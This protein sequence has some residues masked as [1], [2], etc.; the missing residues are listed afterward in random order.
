MSFKKMKN[1]FALFLLLFTPLTRYF[2][3]KT[4]MKSLIAVA[5]FALFL[6]VNAHASDTLIVKKYRSVGVQSNTYLIDHPL[7]F[8]R[9]TS[10]TY[11]HDFFVKKRHHLA[12]MPQFG[13]LNIPNIEQKFIFSAALQYKFVGKRRFEAAAFV[14]VNY[15]LSKLDYDVFE[16][17]GTALVNKGNTLNHFGPSAGVT[18]GFKVWKRPTYSITPFLGISVIQFGQTYPPNLFKNYRQSLNIGVNVNFH[19]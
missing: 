12:V 17:E 9:G 7:F 11:T 10:I 19:K 8:N 1:V 15:V 5:I 2:K 4:R 18:L 14:G 13:V 6:G 3:N 16:Y